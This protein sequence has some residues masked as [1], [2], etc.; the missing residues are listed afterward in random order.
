MVSEGHWINASL[1]QYIAI[2]RNPENGCD[3]Q[4][5]ADGVHGIMMQSELV[6][7]S[8]EEDIHSPE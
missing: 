8:S 5:A 1:P 2:Y 3:T 6:K 4:N 7:T